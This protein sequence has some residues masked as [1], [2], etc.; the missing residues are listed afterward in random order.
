MKRN[1]RKKTG[2][3]EQLLKSKAGKADAD[4]FFRLE[5]PIQTALYAKLCR[6][7]YDT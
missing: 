2:K 7:G 1:T 6:L 3:L 4:L 5:Q